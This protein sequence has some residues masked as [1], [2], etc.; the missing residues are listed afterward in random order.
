MTIEAVG[1]QHDWAQL[2]GAR[3]VTVTYRLLR[4]AESRQT[5]LVRGGFGRRCLLRDVEISRSCSRRAGLAQIAL[6]RV[7]RVGVFALARGSLAV[8]RGR[9]GQVVGMRR[10][11]AS[12]HPGRSPRRSRHQRPAAWPIGQ[13]RNRYRRSVA[14]TPARAREERPAIRQARRSGPSA[15]RTSRRIGGPFPDLPAGALST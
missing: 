14:R 15:H 10:R 3:N 7:A 4:S 8:R 6:R 5:V 12:P 2:H 1:G 13:C 9:A 11:R